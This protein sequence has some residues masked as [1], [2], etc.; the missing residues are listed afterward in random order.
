MESGMEVTISYLVLTL[1]FAT[2]CRAIDKQG[3][4]E[5]FEKMGRKQK[6]K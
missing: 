4:L 1:V 6:L 3:H 5:V 2:A